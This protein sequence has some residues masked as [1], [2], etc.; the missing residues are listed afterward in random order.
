[1]H[2]CVYTY[3]L[4]ASWSAFVDEDDNDEDDDE[5]KEKHNNI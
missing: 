2:L 1:M 5:D 3:I 4:I